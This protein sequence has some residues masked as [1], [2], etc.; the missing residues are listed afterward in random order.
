MHPFM[1]GE[2]IVYP[3]YPYLIGIGLT[4]GLAAAM[5]LK[6]RRAETRQQ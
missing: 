5:L 1:Q 3:N 2:L 4:I 6:W